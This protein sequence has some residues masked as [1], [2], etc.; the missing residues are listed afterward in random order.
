MGVQWIF[1]TDEC[2]MFN[3]GAPILNGQLAKDVREEPACIEAIQKCFRKFMGFLGLQVVDGP[4]LV[5]EK[6]EHFNERIRDCWKPMFGGNHNWLRI[7]RVL[8][9]LRLT[10]LNDEA[11]AFLA[12]LEKLIKE[13]KIP[14]QGSLPHWRDRAATEI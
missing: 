4:P 3:M 7:S 11:A 2:S 14:A 8:H 1:P 10:G 9:C 5:V 13:D 6:A 12:C